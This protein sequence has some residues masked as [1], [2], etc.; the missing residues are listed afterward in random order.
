MWGIGH[1]E[2]EHLPAAMLHHEEHEQD[3]Q[4]DCRNSE[5]VDRH[6]L[7]EMIAK[8]R[9]Q[10]GEALVGGRSAESAKPYALICECRASSV[11]CEFAVP[12]RAHWRSPSAG[13]TV[14]SRRR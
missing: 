9:F 5:E 3:S 12:A 2:V 13:P 1:I 11:R 10:V 8:K 7:T 14:E 4:P 6:D